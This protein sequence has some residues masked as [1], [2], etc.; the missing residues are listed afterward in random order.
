MKNIKAEQLRNVG[1]FSHGGAGKTSLS[2]AMLFDVGVINRLGRVD[3]GTTVS[4]YDPDETKRHISV[5]L[6]LL[7]FEWKGTKVN[8][9]DTP[10]Y[11]DFIGEVREA[12]RV[13]DSALVLFDAVA[14]IEVGSETMWKLADVRQLARLA[15]VNRIDRENADFFRVA[16]QLRERFGNGVV[17]IQLPIGAQN[18]FR[19]I[20]DLI[21]IKAYT[22]PKLEDA[23]IPAEM[24]DQVSEYREKLVE[25]AAEHDDEL[26]NKYLEGEQLTEEE[27]RR[28]VRNATLAGKLVPVLITSATEN[29]GV[30]LVMDAIVEYLPSPV[31]MGDVTAT[32]A[33][34]NQEESLAPSESSPL[35]ALVFKTTADPYVGKLTYFRVYSGEVR[36]DSQVYNANKNRDE[37]I[38]QLFT[39]RGKTQEPVDRVGA[40]DLGAVAKLQETST[41]DTLSSKDHPVV[42]PGISFPRPAYTAALEPKTKV[43]LDKLGPS[44]AR[45]VEEDPTLQVRKDPDTSETLMSGMGESHVDIAAERMKRKFGVDVV[46]S[47]PKIPYK[48]TITMPTKAEYKHKKQTGGHGQYGH[49]FL[50]LQPQSRG[51]GFEFGDKVVGGVV[52]KN[53]VPAVEKGVREA[54][55]QGVLAGYP[56]VDVKVVLYDGSYHPVDSSEMAFKIASSQ[57]F[58]KGMESGKPVLLEPIMDVTVT[59]PEQYMGDVMGDLNSKRA[60]VLGMEPQ[61][62]M[63]IIKA[64]APLAEMQH[65][66]ADLRSITQGRGLY[67]MEFSHYEEVPAHEA[68]SIIAEAK[69]AA[70]QS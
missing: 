39:I 24:N 43:D 20:V 63:S 53:Y 3:E 38:G 26:I 41:G 66:A 54:L 28:G 13:V 60:R 2:E 37:R 55:P 32:N 9:I 35:A 67:T 64:L 49:V 56:V 36:S 51:A 30:P 68:Q 7:P 34:T 50:E 70:A 45:L 33:Q 65:Y 62:G 42:L 47:T 59:V 61:D 69:K 46:L 21:S 52:P 27:V 25:A 15:V 8:I 4:D 23:P 57:A 5:Q 14:G 1:L 58:K 12:M 17:P 10:G 48:E 6:S 11:F 44:L 16:E 19:G 18:N 22:F 31:D 40:G 29:K